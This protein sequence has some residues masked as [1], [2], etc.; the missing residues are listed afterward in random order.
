MSKD[1]YTMLQE[2]LNRLTSEWVACHLTEEIVSGFY[3][4]AKEELDLELAKKEHGI[5]GD[6][7]N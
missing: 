3:I 4:R 2:K 5:G 1:Y 6:D 7:E